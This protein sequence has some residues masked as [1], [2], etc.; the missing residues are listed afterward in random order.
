MH[1]FGKNEK[2]NEWNF[3]GNSQWNWQ[4]SRLSSRRY[5]DFVPITVSMARECIL[6][7]CAL[8]GEFTIFALKSNRVA[9]VQVKLTVKLFVWNIEF[10]WLFKS[11]Q[12]ALNALDTQNP[13]YFLEKT[14]I[15]F[16]AFYFDR[17]FFFID[18]SLQN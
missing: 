9:V 7:H 15:F 6:A 5:A 8:T 4:V 3:N 16:K 11:I 2:K 12:V 17:N 1:L 13:F 14:A 18:N 10:E